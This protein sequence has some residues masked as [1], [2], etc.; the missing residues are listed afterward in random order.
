MTD[1][2]G[3]PLISQNDCSPVPVFHCHV[4]LRK[5]EATGKLHARLANL[6]GITAAGNSERDVLTAITR[7]FKTAMQQHHEAGTDV[8]WIEPARQPE[9]GEFERFIPVHL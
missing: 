8:P 4:L 2:G 6:E 5:N 7:Q 3:L 1:D 9:D